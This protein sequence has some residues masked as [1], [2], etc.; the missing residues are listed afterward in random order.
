[1]IKN[2]LLFVDDICDSGKTILETKRVYSDPMF[3]VLVSKIPELVDYTPET[4][5]ECENKW[6]IF[7]WEK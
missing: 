1:M 5:F 4:K 2:E 6:V 7:P 3:A